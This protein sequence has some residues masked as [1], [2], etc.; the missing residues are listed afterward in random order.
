MKKIFTSGEFNDFKKSSLNE[1]RQPI[2][3][4]KQQFNESLIHYYGTTNYAKKKITIFISHKHD[5]LEDLKDIIG[6]LEKTYDVKCYIDSRDPSMPKITSGET[7]TRIKQRI[8]ECDKFILLASNGAIDSKWCNWELGY[9]DAQ[10]FKDHIALF[11]FK[12][13]EETYKGSEYMQIYPYIVK[14][15]GNE[16]YSGGD[17]VQAGYY[18]CTTDKNGRDFLIPLK[19][20]LEK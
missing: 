11:P 7:A 3:D 15:Y 8:N 5:D 6:F 16:T 19:T 17:S 20:W 2:S 18:I 1:A 10:K 9:G 14:T 4:S 13:K 12:K